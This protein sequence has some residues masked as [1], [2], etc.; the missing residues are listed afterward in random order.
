MIFDE[1]QCGMGRTGRFF[2]FEHFNVVPDILTLGKA[3][4]GGM[5][6]GVLAS[7]KDLLDEFTYNPALGHIT[8]FGGHP[9]CC[10]A[11]V[12]CIETIKS[13]VDWSDLEE[14]GAFLQN[15]I[16]SSEEIKECRRIGFMFAFDM[17]SS[18]RVQKVVDKCL[19]KGVLLF[20]FLS[21]PNSFRISPPLNM[22]MDELKTA[23]ALINE[24]ILET[25]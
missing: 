3:L 6:I 20:W 21:H 5:P 1:I 25:T 15:S 10:A 9:V 16:E 24:A 13:E 18:Q 14:K 11:S 2:A 8:T 19:E 23:V 4:G 7:S 17:E 12:A 22:T